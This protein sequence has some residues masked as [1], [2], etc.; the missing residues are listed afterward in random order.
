M[1]GVQ[2]TLPN[3]KGYEKDRATGMQLL[4]KMSSIT[5][6]APREDATRTG[7]MTLELIRSSRNSRKVDESTVTNAP[8]REPRPKATRVAP[9]AISM[10]FMVNQLD[11][12]LFDAGVR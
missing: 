9:N 1:G 12:T 6:T 11:S 3:I 5:A 4:R 7:V 2:R 10:N 8:A